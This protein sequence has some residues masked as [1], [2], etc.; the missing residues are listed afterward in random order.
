ML[1]D[2]SGEP[3]HAGH[4]PLHPTFHATVTARAGV[5]TI[6]SRGAPK[7]PARDD[8]D[9]AGV[10]TDR[11]VAPDRSTAGPGLRPSAPRPIAASGSDCCSHQSLTR[12]ATRERRRARRYCSATPHV[13]EEVGGGGTTHTV[14]SSA[15][16]GTGDP[17]QPVRGGRHSRAGSS[18]GLA[19]VATRHPVE[20][21]GGR[22]EL[23]VGVVECRGAPPRRRSRRL[24]SRPLIARAARAGSSAS[25]RARAGGYRPTAAPRP[26]TG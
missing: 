16:N 22:Q 26:S 11:C 25:R 18:A 5:A 2:S 1:L 24:W 8:G 17:G 13:G 3:V 20:G 19:Q 15:D 23:D 4:R 14:S 7:P 12:V 9:P 10:W 6:S 21:R